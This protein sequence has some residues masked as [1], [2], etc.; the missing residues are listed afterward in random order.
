MYQPA[1]KMKR[2]PGRNR[3]SGFTLFEVLLVLALI[4]LIGAL[5]MPGFSRTFEN[6]RL[7]EAGDIIRTAWAKGRIE[8]M[9]SGRTMLFRHEIGSNR[10]LLEPWHGNDEYVEL[11]DAA[12]ATMLLVDEQ[13]GF[14]QSKSGEN[15]S[16]SL[17]T[18]G[19]IHT[20][21]EGIKFF[22]SAQEVDARNLYLIQQ[23]GMDTTLNTSYEWSPPILFYPD[24]S[25]SQAQLRLANST[26]QR[27]V[28]LRL[29]GLTGIAYVSD[30]LVATELQAVSQ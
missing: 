28:Q 5:A 17:V 7:R 25:A 21:P 23:M 29:R 6:Q 22:D 26:T 3:S 8:A 18:F 27:F 9:K 19:R 14:D 15:G 12:A 16:F 24:G 10:Y 13:L 20:L 2:C 1:E 11:G 4:I 30:I